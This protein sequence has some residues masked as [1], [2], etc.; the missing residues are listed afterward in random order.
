MPIEWHRFKCPIEWHV[1]NSFV[2]TFT[3]RMA[4]SITFY[5]N[6]FSKTF[7][8]VVAYDSVIAE[9]VSVV[10]VCVFV[11]TFLMF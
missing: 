2:T 10:C 1:A 4:D 9:H 11:A 8:P 7:L 5:A 3:G 6:L